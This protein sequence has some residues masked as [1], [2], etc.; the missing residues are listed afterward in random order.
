MSRALADPVRTEE[1]AAHDCGQHGAGALTGALFFSGGHFVQVLE[2][3]APVVAARLAELEADPRHGGATVLLRQDDARR[4]F[5]RWHL[6]HL[7]LDGGN[8]L[9]H[10]LLASA[11]VAA[12]RAERLLARLEAMIAAAPGFSG[13][14]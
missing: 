14:A 10:S 9:L 1:A 7:E 5:E 13:R 3:P 2:G 12:E 11:P 4:R 6:G 8:D